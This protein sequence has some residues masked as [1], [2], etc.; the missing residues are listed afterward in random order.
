MKEQLVRYIP[1]FLR[2]IL[3]KIYVFPLGIIDRL[4]NRNSMVP[5]AR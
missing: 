5:P 1:S 3:R 2:P 4:G